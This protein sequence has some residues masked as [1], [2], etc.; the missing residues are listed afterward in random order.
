MLTETHS[1]P[2]SDSPLPG[3]HLLTAGKKAEFDRNGFFIIPG[4]LN[5]DEVERYLRVADEAD[6]IIKEHVKGAR[7][8]GDLLELRNAVAFSPDIIDLMTHPAAFPYLLDLMGP[9]I[10]LT[11]SHLFIRPPSPAGTAHS[12]KQIDWHRD[13]PNPRPQ[14]M[15]GM[16]PWLYTKIGY[17]LTDTYLPGAG[18]LRV[19]PGSHRYG[20]PPPKLLDDEPHGAI[21]VQVKPGDAVIF[22]NRVLHA[23]GPN[24]SA[25]ARKNIYFGYCWRYLRPIDFITQPD[26][27]LSGADRFQRQLLGDAS[28]ALDFYLPGKNGLPLAEWPDKKQSPGS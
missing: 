1:P 12:F 27:V 8:P 25:I 14:P 5:S 22:E 3:C 10:G 9:A 23:V 20:G 26:S 17:F 19:V 2:A 28:Q 13:G 24:Y 7:Q 11:T 15:H 6:Q 21:E 16:E 18:A 4:A